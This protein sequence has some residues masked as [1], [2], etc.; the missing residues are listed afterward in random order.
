MR[1]AFFVVFVLVI[2]VAFLLHRLG[3]RRPPPE[4]AYAG[5]A[6]LTLWSSTAEVRVPVTTLDYGE[7][8]EVLRQEGGEAQVRTASR[9]VGWVDSR[10]L[11]D[12]PLWREALRLAENAQRMAVEARGHA[13]VRSNLHIEPGRS[14]PVVIQIP[15]G[16]PVALLS[17]RTAEAPAST[18]NTRED[19]WL[20]RVPVK[21]F[22]KVSGWMLGRFVA[23]DLPEPLP[24]YESSEGMHIMAWF[25]LKNIPVSSGAPK[26]E[27]LVAASRG[28]E[29]Q[30]CDFTL[31]RVY[32]WSVVRRQYE[33]AFVES[34][35]CGSLPIE[36]T[37]ASAPNADAYFR[38]RNIGARRAE[39]RVYRM[40]QTE[41]RRIDENDSGEKGTHR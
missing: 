25:V 6:D 4:A 27:F 20:V 13:G 30:P 28:E 3:L 11:L 18:G 31:L 7:R 41:V 9:L 15:A 26:P 29:G 38:F 16:V 24:E 23:L 35:L 17:R 34:G 12:V 5:K 39:E 1:R 22:G 14:S 19:W 37:P 21:N 8:V 2:L 10:R 33:T 40:R 36:V 32:T